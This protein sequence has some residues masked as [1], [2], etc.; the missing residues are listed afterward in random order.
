MENR[1]KLRLGLLRGAI[2]VVAL[3]AAFALIYPASRA[4][5][6]SIAPPASRPSAAPQS[7]S[8]IDGFQN[9]GRWREGTRLVNIRGRFR[10]AGERVQFTSEDE[11]LRFACLEN[12][13]AE[14]VGRIVSESPEN[15]FWIVNGNVTEFRG[16]NYLLLTQAV[17]QARLEPRRPAR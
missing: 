8:R 3:L 17:I 10:V 7:T 9:N 1:P 15:P 14:R 2:A 6:D 12:L 11:A 4:A 5:E 13:A 16:E